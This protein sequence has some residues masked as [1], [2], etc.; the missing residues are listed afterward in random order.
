MDGG[1][2]AAGPDGRVVTVWRRAGTMFTASPGEEEREI[3]RG[4]QGWA[5]IGPGGP[6]SVWLERRPGKLMAQVPGR[7]E[8]L[9]MADRAVD[10][11]VAASP[12][13]RGPVVAVWEVK[14]EEG[15][16]VS[17]VLGPTDE[18]AAR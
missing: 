2:V 18:D 12:G 4:V 3:G 9:T 1:A 17:L 6:Y 15:V 5:A 8:S 10:P 11:V 14:P 13:G 7:R 16:I